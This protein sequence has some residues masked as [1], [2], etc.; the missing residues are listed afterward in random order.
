[1][2]GFKVKA[3]VGSIEGRVKGAHKIKSQ[4]MQNLA[5]MRKVKRTKLSR[6]LETQKQL[7][8]AKGRRG[9]RVKSETDLNEIFKS[10]D[11]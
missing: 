7:E 10:G 4:L 2:A 8:K 5:N 6:G 1:V 9:G 3:E 11:G